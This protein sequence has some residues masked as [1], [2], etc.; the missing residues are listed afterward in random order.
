MVYVLSGGVICYEAV[1]NQNTL[2]TLHSGQLEC[3]EVWGHGR[4]YLTHDFPRFPQ[5]CKIIL[6]TQLSLL[7]GTALQFC[8]QECI[9]KSHNG[10]S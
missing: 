7:K 9:L 2:N 10:T 1:S 8:S 5:G 6:G 3:I 4:L